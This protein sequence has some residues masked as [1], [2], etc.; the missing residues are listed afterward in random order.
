VS[1]L[2]YPLKERLHDPVTER[3]LQRVWRSIDEHAPRRPRRRMRALAL[4]TLALVAGLALG[5]ALRARDAGRMR[6]VEP[7]AQPAP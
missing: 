1:Q 4:A 2:R 7:P 5:L 6:L 3:A